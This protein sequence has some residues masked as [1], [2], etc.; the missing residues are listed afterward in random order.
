LNATPSEADN[1]SRA[2]QQPG[3]SHFLGDSPRQVHYLTWGERGEHKP[4]LMLIHGYRGH[5]HWWDAIAPHFAA[6]FRVIA[7]DL[8]GMGDSDAWPDYRDHSLAENILTVARH[9]CR[10]PAILVAHSF[11]G[12]QALIACLEHPEWFAHAIL[13]DSYLRL[14]GETFP[15]EPPIRPL[16][17]YPDLAT[18]VSRFRLLP[19]QPAGPPEVMTHIARHS[20]RQTAGGWQWKFDPNL[21]SSQLLA[22]IDPADLQSLLVPVDF[23]YGEFSVVV[24]HERAQRTAAALGLRQPPIAIPGAHH[25][26]MIDQP[27]ALTAALR[28]LLARV[29]GD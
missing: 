22:T 4:V 23:I 11:G 6:C 15:V 9:E 12:S 29:T 27:Q 19:E 21:P 25:H 16:R 8:P 2:L 24:S 7:V 5:A 10:S 18:G 20:L 26:V 28:T 3:I 13:I 14:A 1:I 17:T